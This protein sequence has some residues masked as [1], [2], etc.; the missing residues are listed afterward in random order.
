M[1]KILKREEMFIKKKKLTIISPK[2]FERFTKHLLP[3]SQ[4]SHC[5]NI[6][7]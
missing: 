7:I 4:T 6:V 1:M 3:I 2:V 5:E